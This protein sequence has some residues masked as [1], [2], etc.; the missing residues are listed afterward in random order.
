MSRVQNTYNNGEYYY[1]PRSRGDAETGFLLA[2]AASGAIMGT[3][4]LYSKPF[5]QQI[6]Q[7]SVNNPEYLKTFLKA[8]KNTGLNK[9][10]LTLHH[11]E[12][13][14]VDKL[15]PKEQIRDLLI[16]KGENACYV[17]DLKEIR[18]NKNKA[19]ASGFH[20]AG[21][22]MN[23]LQ[24]KVGKLLQKC[25]Y[26]AYTVAGLMGTVALFSRPKP[27]EA[28]KDIKDFLTDNCGKIAFI[29]MLPV[30]A[31]EALASY[32]GVKM[33]KEAGLSEK[34][35]K[36]LKKLY[37]KALLSYGGYAVAT[38]LSVYVASKITEHFTRPKKVK[39][40]SWY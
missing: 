31:E 6:K 32:K 13:T 33:A 29:S 17:P 3:L 8:I 34:L 1:V 12:L 26:P 35:L 36:N 4:P 27:K 7:E 24:S 18:L 10:G 23:H 9:D 16:K 40:D 39:I 30:L 5:T 2:T 21:H 11:L 37:G 25:R 28:K 15:T 38:G 14:P 19:A 22:A 20:E